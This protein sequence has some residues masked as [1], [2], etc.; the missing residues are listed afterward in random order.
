MDETPKKETPK[1][2]TSYQISS[3]IAPKME[4]RKSAQVVSGIASSP[5]VL[6]MIKRDMSSVTNTTSLKI[7]QGNSFIQLKP[8]NISPIPT[9]KVYTI[10]GV[11]Q[12]ANK[13]IITMPSKGTT[14]RIFTTQKAQLPVQTSTPASGFS[15]QK[16]TIIRGGTVK[17]QPDRIEP[18]DLSNILDMPIMFA[19]SDGVLQEAPS[20]KTFLYIYSSVIVMFWLSL[21]IFQ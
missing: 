14:Q 21:R 20:G 11:S 5:I 15:P 17:E 10:K 8:S 7:G 1:I 18:N 12:S 6:P 13:H 16:F 9:Q 2:I 3:E 4:I 19:D